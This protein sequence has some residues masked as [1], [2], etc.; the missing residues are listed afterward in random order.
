MGFEFGN[1]FDFNEAAEVKRSCRND[2]PA[3][4]VFAKK[5]GISS[6][7]GAPVFVGRGIDAAE[8]H[9][10]ALDTRG[11]KHSVEILEG[12]RSMR[13]NVARADL[14]RIRIHGQQPGNVKHA[15]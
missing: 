7:N 1:A 3:G 15:V 9:L 4:F 13:L 5:L 8:N 10:T 14:T 6:V 12:L 2:N 11:F